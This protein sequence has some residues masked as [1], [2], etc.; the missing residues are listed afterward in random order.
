M[1]VALSICLVCVLCNLCPVYK[2]RITATSLFGVKV[3]A[4]VCVCHWTCLTG[5]HLVKLQTVS[6]FGQLAFNLKNSFNTVTYFTLAVG[7]K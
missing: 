7:L 2:Y 4:C 3:R 6:I 5:W 1:K